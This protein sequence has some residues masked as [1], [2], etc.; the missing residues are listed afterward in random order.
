MYRAWE[1]W[2]RASTY[3]VHEVQGVGAVESWTEVTDV[4]GPLVTFRT[5]WSFRSDGEVLTSDST[6]RFRDQDEVVAS[7]VAQGYVVDDVRGAPDRYGR[8]LVFLARKP[9]AA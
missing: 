3:G 4:A 6:L 7:L 9:E 5:T 8:E 1:Q 2:T